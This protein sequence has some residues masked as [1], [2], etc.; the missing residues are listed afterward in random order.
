MARFYSNENFPIQTVRELRRLGHDVLT[1]H[2][3]GNANRS[4]PDH[5]V[6]QFAASQR[7]ILLTQNRLHFLRLHQRNL[8]AH[9]GIVISIYDPDFMRLAAQVHERAG[10]HALDGLLLRVYRPSQ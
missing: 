6:L 3:A 2:E 4:V 10:R 5:E 9:A 1:S 7:R 8:I